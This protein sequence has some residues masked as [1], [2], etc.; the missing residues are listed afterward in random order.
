MEIK[1]LGPL[2]ILA[3]DKSVP[4]AGRRRIGVLARLA[5]EAGQT[6]RTEQILADVWGD[7]S[8]ATAG[9][10]LHIVV[11]KLRELHDPT[12]IASVIATVPGGYRLTV[13]RD[14]IDAHL[15]SRLVERA[16]SARS[17]GSAGTADALFRRALGLWRGRPLSELD[18]PW[19]R[20]E[21]D[22]LEAERL[23]VL[24]EHGEL[25]L[26]AGDH[27][28]LTREYV[29]HV[30]AHPV[31][32]RL[33]AQLMLA[34]HRS[35][36]TPDALARYR[37]ARRALIEQNGVEPSAEL[38]RL[39]QALLVGD[40]VLDLATPEQ[41][42]KVREPDVPAEL[43]GASS[44]FTARTAE[45]AEVRAVLGSNGERTVAAIHGPGGI[46]KSALAIHVAHSMAGR[47][48]DGVIYV[49]LHGSTAGLDPLSPMT[50]L[51]HLLR[52]LGLDGSAVPAQVGEAAARYRSLTA[53]CNLLVI[54]DN[55]HGVDQVR[56]LV[57]AGPRC[58]TLI[59]S[60]A[61]LTT[62][63]NTAQLQLSALTAAD[64]EALLTRLAGVDRIQDEPDALQE[65]LQLCGG[66]PLALRIAGARL[67]ARPD[68]SLRE[69]ALRLSD[70]T[71][72]LDT[73]AYGDLAVRAS[74]AV[75]HQRLGEEPG[76]QDADALFTLLG[77]IRLPTFTAAST[78]A[79]AGWPEHRAEA[80]LEH[81]LDARLV[82]SAGPA[83]YEFHDLVGLYAS[84]QAARV[85][86]ENDRAA[87]L[88]RAHRH[89]LL[90]IWA[91]KFLINPNDVLRSPVELP[92]AVFADQAQMG[93]WLEAE[94]D[95]LLALATRCLDAPDDAVVL[96]L[97]V[98]LHDPFSRRGWHLQL[99]DIYARA[100]D[101]AD[102]V[103]AWES[104]ATLR[105]FLGW[106]YRD[107]GRNDAA[108]R[109]FE[110]ALGDWDRADLPKR[111]VTALN[112][113]GIIALLTGRW[114]EALDHFETALALNDDVERP[115]ATAVI[116]NNRA[117]VYSRQGRVEEAIEEALAAAAL[118]SAVDPNLGAGNAND[119]LGTIYRRA[120]RLSEAVESCAVA[121]PRLRA[122]GHHLKEAVC[123]WHLGATLHA[124]DRH[125]EAREQYR[126]ALDLLVGDLLLTQRE[127]DEILGQDVP[128]TP[129][130]LKNLF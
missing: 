70:T 114:D 121:A 11:S 10:Q 81:L 92:A 124:L 98:G 123:R 74:L 83:R 3:E 25:R 13:E 41:Q 68:W 50:A 61:A 58:R 91:A 85:L 66:V 12:L 28:A 127:A 27:Q 29:A 72:R 120:G 97:V 73:L 40:P 112:H 64:A 109:Q 48:T 115:V 55:A 4:V 39:H 113:L 24:E 65:I 6:V 96:D 90:N 101:L 77:L 125:D 9:K 22:R 102:R 128:E 111:K 14:Q 60:R 18:A 8:A 105:G 34:L 17:H 1:Y 49:N 7:S 86:P 69:L 119:S 62:L 110:L 76:G 5:V 122:S 21:A 106:A 71:R 37:N 108:R 84:E 44:A 46:G 95:N 23:A 36:R 79:V 88:D 30:E 63:D 42:V 118:W 107:Q 56:A 38:R 31:R 53:A 80:A 32:E 54:L 43:P 126:K 2:E 116:R 93:R 99:T 59:T 33:V 94:R 75:S 52:S 47:F 15:F 89:Y 35:S 16:R 78:A 57:P 87:A 129:A 67:A 117:H 100:V 130:P 20:Q 45:A 104:K 82:E 19:A 51:R 26:A 103:G